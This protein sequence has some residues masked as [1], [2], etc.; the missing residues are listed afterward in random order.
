MA[1]ASRIL[2]LRALYPGVAGRQSVSAGKARY[3]R[4]DHPFATG[5]GARARGRSEFLTEARNSDGLQVS[6]RQ[7]SEIATTDGKRGAVESRQ[8]S[9]KGKAQSGLRVLSHAWRDSYFLRKSAQLSVA[10]LGLAIQS[11]KSGPW[12][13]YDLAFLVVLLGFGL[14]R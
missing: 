5:A 10:W 1:G 14:W 6:R 12:S 8:T 11:A 4:P 2:S 13:V 3:R 9:D 7:R